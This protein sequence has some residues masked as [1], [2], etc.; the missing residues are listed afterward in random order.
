MNENFIFL[1][2]RQQ[3]KFGPILRHQLEVFRHD[4]EEPH[5]A[6]QLHTQPGRNF[7]SDKIY[8][9]LLPRSQQQVAYQRGVHQRK[10]N[11]II[12][13]TSNQRD[14][15]VVAEWSSMSIIC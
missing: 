2:S 13:T 11:L 12:H 10:K 8:V 4:G 9:H 5:L 14:R 6:V 3:Q 15:A 7:W 1:F